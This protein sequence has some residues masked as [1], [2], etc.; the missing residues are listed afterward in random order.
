ML[1][2]Y[3]TLLSM[4]K[5]FMTFSEY[6]NILNTTK[7]KNLSKNFVFFHNFLPCTLFY[8]SLGDFFVLGI[9]TPTKLI[10]E[11]RY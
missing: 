5:S 3:I 4:L 10:V 11:N 2:S 9:C 6:K 8:S 7:S 1:N